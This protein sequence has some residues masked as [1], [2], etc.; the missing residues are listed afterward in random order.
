MLGSVIRDHDGGDEDSTTFCKVVFA[1]RVD[2][3]SDIAG[4]KTFVYRIDVIGS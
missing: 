1:I 3:P 4:D 2:I